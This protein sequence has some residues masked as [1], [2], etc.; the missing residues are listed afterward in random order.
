MRTATPCRFPITAA[1]A[2]CGVL[3]V[4]TTASADP[5]TFQ[6]DS[7]FGTIE[8]ITYTTVDG[9][10]STGPI[11]LSLN[12]SL[13]IVER[14][15]GFLTARTVMDVFFNDGRGG[16]LSG[17]ALIEESGTIE[18]QFTDIASGI[19]V[20]AGPFSG[21]LVKGRNPFKWEYDD[22]TI[23]RAEHSSCGQWSTTSSTPFLDCSH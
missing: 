7:L 20:G 21:T 6:F 14:D 17:N 19:L 5:I 4:A 22:P 18:S 10:F 9:T 12:N 23:Q 1:A 3:G 15:T 8:P 2:L 13:V 11:S 16:E